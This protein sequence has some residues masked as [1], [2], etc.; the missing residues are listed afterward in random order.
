[1]YYSQYQENPPAKIGNI[2][3]N[4]IQMKLKGGYIIDEIFN[5]FISKR[6]IED[7]DKAIEEF[8]KVC[9]YKLEGVEDFQ[10]SEK[11]FRVLSPNRIL[12]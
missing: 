8:S 4:E 12:I 3:N 5:S 11:R 10:L 1:V 7:F 6:G 9:C 2:K